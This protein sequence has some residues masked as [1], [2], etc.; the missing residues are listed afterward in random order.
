MKSRLKGLQIALVSGAALW[1]AA[2]PA[3]AATITNTGTGSIAGQTGTL[4]S[5]NV[6]LDVQSLSITKKVYDL[7]GTELAGSNNKVAKGQTVWVV[8]YVDNTSNATVQDVRVKDNLGDANGDGTTGDSSGMS[9]VA[10]SMEYL[11]GSVA[12]ASSP[13]TSSTSPGWFHTGGN[14]TAKT[15][16]FSNA[17][18]LGLSSGSGATAVLSMGGTNVAGDNKT[19]DLQP[20]KITA[21]RFKVTIN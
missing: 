21:F 19:V 6:S 7:A 14:W 12:S 10:S 17:D 16:T 2:S 20:L 13:G 9:Y 5:G 3:M 8:L 15:D 18:E 4:T 11:T 1:M